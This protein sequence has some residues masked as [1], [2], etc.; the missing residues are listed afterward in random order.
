MYSLTLYC[1]HSAYDIIFNKVSVK[2][3]DIDDS[4]LLTLY[5]EEILVFDII[6]RLL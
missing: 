6:I 4:A 1:N 5:I 3:G 2:S